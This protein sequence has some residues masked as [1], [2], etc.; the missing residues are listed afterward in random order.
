MCT[1]KLI[2]NYRKSVHIYIYIYI[3]L[4]IYLCGLVHHHTML[5]RVA[6]SPSRVSHGRVIPHVTLLSVGFQHVC[7][8]VCL[9]V[10]LYV[11]M[12]ACVYVCMMSASMHAGVYVWKEVS[13]C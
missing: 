2:N 11:F 6:L 13:S 12:S 4:F 8:H 7:M 1:Q 3:Y 10:C 9:P 5:R